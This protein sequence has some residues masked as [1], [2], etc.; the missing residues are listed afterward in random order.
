MEEKKTRNEELYLDGLRGAT[1]EELA[2]KYGVSVQ[3]AKDICERE[4]RIV[5]REDN[6]LYVAIRDAANDAQLTE[7]TW[8]VLTRHGVCTVDDVRKLTDKEL[9]EF[10]NCGPVMRDLLRRI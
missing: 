6:P 3:R 7:K 10:R 2:E 8:T 1:Y 9:K 4:S 5:A